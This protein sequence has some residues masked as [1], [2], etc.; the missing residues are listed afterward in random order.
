MMTM[1][2]LWAP[3][4]DQGRCTTALQLGFGVWTPPDGPVPIAG[5]PIMRLSFDSWNGGVIYGIAWND[6]SMPIC[7]LIRSVARHVCIVLRRLDCGA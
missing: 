7:I 5:L 3:F 2:W 1:G 6:N 4:A